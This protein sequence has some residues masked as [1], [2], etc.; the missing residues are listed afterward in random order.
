MDSTKPIDFVR[1]THPF[2]S[3]SE[4]ELKRVEQ[5]LETVQLTTGTHVLLQDG[6]PSHHL[7]MIR[8]GEMRVVRDGQVLQVLGESAFFGYP[9]M[10]NQKAPP[11]DVVAEED[12]LI[13]RIPEAIF[14]ELIGN[15]TFAEFFLHNLSERLRLTSRTETPLLSEDLSTPIGDLI[16]GPPIMVSPTATVAEVAQAMLKA[17]MNAALVTDEPLGIVTDRD[18]LFRVLAQKLGPETLV[19]TVMSQP[20]KTFSSETPV[21]AA[22]LFMLQQ[23]DRHLALTQE[24]RIVGVITTDDLLRHQAK[25]PLYFLKQLEQSGHPGKTLTEYALDVAGTVET[26]YKG[27]LEVAQIGRIVASL[28]GALVRKLLRLAEEELGPPP[29]PYAWIV[30]G[31]EGRMEQML[32]TDQDNALIYQEDTTEARDYFKTLAERVV[33]GLINAGF[34]P[35]PGG[36]MAT[37][38][39][40]PLGDWVRL[41]KSWVNTPEP[42]AL[43]KACIFFDFHSVY[44]ELSLK[45]LEQVLFETGAQSIFLAHMSKTALEFRP[46]LGLFHRIRSEAGQIDLKKAGVAPIVAMARFYA[47]EAGARTRSTFKRLEAAAEAGTLSQ[48]GAEAL[49]ETYRFL[50]HLRLQQQLARHRTGDTP[51]NK[52]RLESLST[53]QKRYLK[54]AFIVIRELQKSISHRF[55]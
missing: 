50:L 5:T 20:V 8:K 24:G 18:F 47:L 15:A 17:R 44:G 55:S 14:H 2:D 28:N 25:N 33:N 31:S 16:A 7:Y 13:Y 3:L 34:P 48:D 46:P 21:Y 49:A 52:I 35:C 40:Q 38:W 11:V 51:D 9:S 19:H 27:G 45:P 37:N 26:L 41:F 23:S 53:R 6:A 43:L 29:T 39:C 10:L 4:A 36:Y 32:L 42:D 22:L 1:I 30:F 54:E 12:A